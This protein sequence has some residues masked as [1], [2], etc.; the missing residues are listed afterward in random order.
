M[1][2]RWKNMVITSS[3][4]PDM[5][6]DE[7]E[8]EYYWEKLEENIYKNT[9]NKIIH[10]WGTDTNGQLGTGKQ[11]K[12]NKNIG[13]NTLKRQNE[14]GNGVNLAKLIKKIGMRAMNTM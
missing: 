9:D 4:A 10:I 12:K 7:R 3:Y 6:H 2:I 5:N 8:R 1:D 14:K 13:K 11:R